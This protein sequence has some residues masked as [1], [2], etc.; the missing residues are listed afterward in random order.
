MGERSNRPT[1]TRKPSAS[2]GAARNGA[3]KRGDATKQAPARKSTAKARPAKAGGANSVRAKAVASA[4]ERASAPAPSVTVQDVN[5][6]HIFAL[7]P[8]VQP[9]FNPEA[10]RGARRALA[11]E[12]YASV[13]EAARAL[14]EKAVELSN[15]PGRDAFQ[16]R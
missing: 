15:A 12:K 7:R 14:A 6:G 3:P 1:G 11:E 8:R 5:L 4:S 13:A 16:R 9:G 10:F 2:K